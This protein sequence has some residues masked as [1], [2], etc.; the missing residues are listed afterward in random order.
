MAKP[1][2]AAKTAVR[3]NKKKPSSKNAAI[4]KNGSKTRFNNPQGPVFPAAD[5]ERARKALIWTMNDHDMPKEVLE[6]KESTLA[7]YLRVRKIPLYLTRAVIDEL[8]AEGVFD[9]VR[10]YY[11]LTI[12]VPL[13]GRNQTDHAVPN[14]RLRTTRRRWW[15]Y[16]ELRAE[17]TKSN[18]LAKKN[19]S[20]APSAREIWKLEIVGST[21]NA[22]K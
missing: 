2:A 7:E 4:V 12:F 1:T 3:A 11:D 9:V 20:Q 19:L 6:F 13:D 16:L 8:V 17:G 15:T 18:A 21:A 14:R 22:C 5:L 10:E